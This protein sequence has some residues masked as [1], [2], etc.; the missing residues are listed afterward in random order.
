MFAKLNEKDKQYIV[1][2][3]I[4]DVPISL[5]I[6][7]GTCVFPAYSIQSVSIEYLLGH[8]HKMVF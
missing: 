6:I 7:K 5:I 3:R 1:I 2:P 4:D 8:D